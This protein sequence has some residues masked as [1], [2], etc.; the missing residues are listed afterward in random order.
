MTIINDLS[1]IIASKLEF[2][3]HCHGV[4]A[5][6]YSIELVC[7]LNTF[8]NDRSL[9][10]KLFSVFVF[11]IFLYDSPIWPPHFVKDIVV[12]ERLHNI[13]LKNYRKGL[14]YKPSKERLSILRLPTLECRRAYNDLIFLYKIIHGLADITLLNMFPPLAFNS[15][16]V[17][18]HHPC[19]LNLPLSRDDLLKY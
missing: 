2:S 7:Y 5:K 15:N 8:T 13:S 3:T 11:P 4:A 6:D 16:L 1:F 18:R 12:M 14:R 9:Q 19:Q 10:C 17:L